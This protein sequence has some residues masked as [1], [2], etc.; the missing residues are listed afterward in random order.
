MAKSP[1]ITSAHLAV[2]LGGKSSHLRVGWGS[3]EQIFF[4]TQSGLKCITNINHASV[5][6]TSLLNTHA[7]HQFFSSLFP[8]DRWR[9][10]RERPRCFLGDLFCPG[11]SWHP[12]KNFMASPGS[13]TAS[14]GPPQW[15]VPCLSLNHQPSYD[16]QLLHLAGRDSGHSWANQPTNQIHLVPVRL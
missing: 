10:F 6:Y 5:G 12:S 4:F 7:C 15:E 3:L 11:H 1:Q 8:F 14:A 2:C 16:S 9:R 13:V